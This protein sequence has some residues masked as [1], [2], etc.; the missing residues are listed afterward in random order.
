MF[1]FSNP[2]TSTAALE[3]AGF[4]EVS[5]EKL[6]NRY[7]GRTA[8]D[9][10]DWLEKSTVRTMALFRLQTAEVQERIREEIVGAARAYSIDDGVQIPCPAVL[11]AARKP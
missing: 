6:P 3:R 11:Y 10:F 5:S 9:V 7:V 2:A 1:E 8:E 4:Q